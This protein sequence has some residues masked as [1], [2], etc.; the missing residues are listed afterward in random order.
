MKLGANTMTERATEDIW[1]NTPAAYAPDSGLTAVDIFAGIGGFHIAAKYNGV[2]VT[3]ASEIDRFAAHC[4]ETNLGLAPHGDIRECKDDIPQHDILMAGFPCQPFSIMGKGRGFG[5]SQGRGA[6]LFEVLSI[7][8]RMRPK[9]VIMENVRRFSTHNHGKTLA[10]VAEQFIRCGYTPD[11]RILNAMDFGLPQKRER[12]FIVALRDGIKP[13]EW[14][15][16]RSKPPSLAS[17]L[18]QG[19]V[20]SRYYSSPAIRDKRRA[21]HE[22]DVRPAVWHENIGKTITSHPYS[23]ALQAESS[24]NYLLVDGERR[25]TEREMLRLQGFAEAYLPTGTYTQTK[26]QTGNAVPIPVASQVLAAVVK[27]LRSP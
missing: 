23:C 6:L 9:A 17:I 5:D 16:P 25:F 19:E 11:A 26:R 2:K 21:K 15:T 18:E 10:S 27:V 3:F 24:Y 7:A 1:A 12:T 13:I 4:Y 22:T 14:P 20:P 8:K